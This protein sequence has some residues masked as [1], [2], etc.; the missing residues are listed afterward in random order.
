MGVHGRV[1]ADGAIRGR[2]T[3]TAKAAVGLLRGIAATIA[4]Y[5]T[6]RL[7]LC[8]LSVAMHEAIAV[9]LTALSNLVKTEIIS[10]RK[11]S[12]EDPTTWLDRIAALFRDT[13]ARADNGCQ[14]P[15]LPALLDAWPVLKQ[16]MHKYQSDSR[17][18]ERLSRA[19]R[20]ALRCI[21]RHAAPILEELAHEMAAV[22]AA[23]S[24]SCLLYLASILVDE[25]YQEP[26]CT[27]Y[28][29]GLLQSLM[30]GAFDLLQKPNGL[31]DNPDTVDDL[32]RLCIRSV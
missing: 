3:I 1:A 19:I 15:C 23:H 32:F 22:Y 25:L 10:F 4:V 31:R 18:M 30:P 27:Q 13:E 8:Q 9:Q 7:S 21:G 26:A 2:A 17:V 12:L 20:F 6:I 5:H 16:V 28:L 29:I 24:H 14:H 11:Y